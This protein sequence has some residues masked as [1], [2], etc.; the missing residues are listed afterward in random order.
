VLENE[1]LVQRGVLVA[2]SGLDR[3]DDLTRD[4]QL[5]EVPE[6]GLTVGPIVPNRFVET[7]EALLD[8]IVGVAAGEEVR[9]GLEPNEAVVPAHDAVVRVRMPLLG[10]GYQISILNLK[11]RVRRG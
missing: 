5:G 1:I 11:L 10:E 9:R 6:A 7:D 3:G 8:Q 4:A 2:R